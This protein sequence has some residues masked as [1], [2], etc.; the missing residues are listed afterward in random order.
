LRASGFQLFHDFVG[1]SVCADNQVNVIGARIDGV[2]LPIADSA[3]IGNGLFDDFAL[4]VVQ[5]DRVFDHQVACFL[6]E[7]GIW[8]LDSMNPGLDPPA[9]ITG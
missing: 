1:I 6:F 7:F 5:H 8:F 2:Q 4:F 9:L 3:M